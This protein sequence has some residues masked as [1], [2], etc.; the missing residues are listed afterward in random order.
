VPKPTSSLFPRT[1][2]A[3]QSY[4][5]ITHHTPYIFL[6]EQ[7]RL[8]MLSSAL[9][10]STAR[11][12]ATR[13]V[14]RH[15]L[16]LSSWPL[17]LRPFSAVPKAPPASEKNPPVITSTEAAMK[18]AKKSLEDLPVTFS[19]ICRAQVAIRDGVTRTECVK[20]FFLSELIGANIYI[21]P[22]FRQFTGSFKERG[23][24]N[25]IMQLM[26]ERG[27]DLKGVIA[28]SAGNHALALA[29]HGKEL[30]VPVTVVM[31]VVAPLAKVD[32]CRVSK[33]EWTTTLDKVDKNC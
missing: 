16:R 33:I 12:A 19:D 5:Y 4:R 27:S 31:P 8:T 22:E 9:T 28:A 10:R 32:K 29:Y 7:G 24:R 26:R 13:T 3:I 25:A 18:A 20:S 17:L 2:V 11:V 30:G 1:K 14:G 21:K 6:L 15:A 23:A